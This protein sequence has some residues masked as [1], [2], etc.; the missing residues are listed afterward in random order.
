[1]LGVLDAPAAVA[2]AVRLQ[3]V[4]EQVEHDRDRLVADCVDAQ[5]EARA[6]GPDQPAAHRLDRLHLVGQQAARAGSVRVRLE[7]VGRRRAER[8][9]GV[10]LERAEAEPR[11]A[12]GAAQTEARLVLPL[13]L[14]RRGGDPQGE[15]TRLEQ[16]RVGGHVLVR[17]VHVLDAREAE[18][19]GVPQPGADRP[20]PG[21]VRHRRHHARHEADRR[22]LEDP[23]RLAGSVAHDLAAR[24]RL[25]VAGHPGEPQRAAVR[26]RHVTV[27]AVHEHRRVGR[28]R[29]E[30]LAGGQP[31]PRERLVVPRP[32]EHPLALP[33]RP[34]VLR[35][36]AGELLGRACVLQLHLRELEARVHEVQVGVVEPRDDASA[37]G[38][39][40]PRGRSRPRLDVPRRTDRHDPLA[41]DGDRLGLRPR[42]V[43]GPD[44]TVQHDEVGRAVLRVLGRARG[45]GHGR[46]D[47]EEGDQGDGGVDGHCRS[48]S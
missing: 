13:S 26:E 48:T 28:Q 37:A 9:V 2:R 25:R 6:I 23:R 33:E 36:A 46:R 14:E 4:F 40:A 17:R 24:R 18:R 1:M 27:V 47:E 20:H 12:E 38:V 8:A 43:A 11:R 34:S 22:V 7:E 15:L 5:L 10:A 41:E 44:A 30:V 21:I 19:G 42:G 31:R 32:A 39:D 29:V 35:D 16:L 45:P 3:D